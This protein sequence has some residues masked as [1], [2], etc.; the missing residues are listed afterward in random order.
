MLQMEK[1]ISLPATDYGGS[2]ST[3]SETFFFRGDG[4][5]LRRGR[6]SFF[7][8]FL[9]SS[10]FLIDKFLQLPLF[11]SLP[12]LFRVKVTVISSLHLNISLFFYV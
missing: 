2:Q 3:N 12:V 10:H 11:S 4:Q 9:F 8:F 7:F 6:A 1:E 5:F